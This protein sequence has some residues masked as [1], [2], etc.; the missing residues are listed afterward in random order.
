MCVCVCVCTYVVVILTFAMHTF[1]IFNFKV[2]FWRLNNKFLKTN[3]WTNL[4]GVAT[5]F[6]TLTPN[7]N[8]ICSCSVQF[9]LYFYLGTVDCWQMTVC[10]IHIYL[11]ASLHLKFRGIH[12]INI[13]VSLQRNIISQLLTFTITHFLKMVINLKTIGM[14]F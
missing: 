7:I 5:I 10:E 13:R 12:Q 14:S 9:R 1:N 3:I 8:F 2:K 6:V 4:K 11:I